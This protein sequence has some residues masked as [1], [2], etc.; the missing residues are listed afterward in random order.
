M[1][2]ISNIFSR[3]NNLKYSY[4]YKNHRNDYYRQHNR[5][6]SNR[7]L[8]NLFLKSRKFDIQFNTSADITPL[9]LKFG[10]YYYEVIGELGKPRFEINQGIGKNHMVLFYR[11]NIGDYNFISQLH[12]YANQLVYV[13]SDFDYLSHGEDCRIAILHSLF[14]KYSIQSDYEFSKDIIIK[15]ADNNIISISDGGKI[16]LQYYAGNEEIVNSILDLNIKNISLA[17][18]TELEFS[19]MQTVV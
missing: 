18:K 19:L 9:N 16:S 1:N 13:K 8:S 6:I 2:I 14:H 11:K 10:T 3:R 15:D 17:K 12:F 5:I 4:G 7:V